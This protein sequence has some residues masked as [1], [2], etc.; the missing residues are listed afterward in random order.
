MGLAVAY[1]IITSHSGTITVSSIPGQGATF[2]VYLPQIQVAT[3]DGTHIEEPL[4]TGK[5]RLL[6]VEDE[7]AV[8][9]VGQTLLERLGYEVVVCLRSRK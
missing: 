9:H 7:T 4:S 5:E 8:A 2:E 1:G 3:T 6:L